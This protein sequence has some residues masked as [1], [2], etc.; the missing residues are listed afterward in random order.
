MT[1]DEFLRLSDG[2]L[3][4]PSEPAIPFLAKPP[5]DNS[6]ALQCWVPKRINNPVPQGRKKLPASFR[7]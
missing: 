5:P 1:M 2:L 6:P 7:D 3:R 4:L